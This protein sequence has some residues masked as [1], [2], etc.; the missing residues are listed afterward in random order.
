M[1]F[2]LYFSKIQFLLYTEIKYENGLFHLKNF[3]TFKFEINII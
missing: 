1:N 2:E 3:F